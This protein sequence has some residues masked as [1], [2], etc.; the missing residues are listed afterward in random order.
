M[1]IYHVMFRADA[2]RDHRLRRSANRYAYL[3]F[4]NIPHQMWNISQVV[5]KKALKNN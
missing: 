3:V 2:W 1:K 5:H 4:D